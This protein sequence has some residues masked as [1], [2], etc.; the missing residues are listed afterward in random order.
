MTASPT[1][2]PAHDGGSATLV[3]LHGRTLVS[4][5]LRVAIFEPHPRPTAKERAA[6]I[7]HRLDESRPGAFFGRESPGGPVG[8]G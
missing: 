4:E 6:G 3:A 8:T 1:V 5:N 2:D 7:R